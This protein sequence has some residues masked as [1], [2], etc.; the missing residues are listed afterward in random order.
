MKNILTPDK[1]NAVASGI[2]NFRMNQKSPDYPAFVLA[3]EIVGSGGFLTA[4][5]PARLRE[6]DGIS[7]GAG[8]YMSI[9]VSDDDVAMWGFYSL[10]NPTKRDAVESAIAE[11]IAKAVKDGVTAKE[12][13][14][15]KKIY[16]NLQ[17]TMLG[18]DESLVDLVN[19]KLQYDVP[20]EDYD[21]LNEKIQG[22]QVDDINKVLKKYF[23]SDNMISVYAGDFNKK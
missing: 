12:V 10:Y 6:K 21:T 22:L 18:M 1:E 11:E 5:I 13:T 4:R 19:T 23:S 16:S 9:P 8:S 17:K 14:D 20:L 2:Y 15:N 7:Y 3:N